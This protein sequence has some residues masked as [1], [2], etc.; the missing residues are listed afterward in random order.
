MKLKQICE[1]I[2]KEDFYD[3]Y[4]LA[5]AAGEYRVRYTGS[6]EHQKLVQD[7]LKYIASII[8]EDHMEQLATILINRWADSNPVSTAKISN[9]TEQNKLDKFYGTVTTTPSGLEI[10]KHEENPPNTRPGN[11]HILDKYN[12]MQTIMGNG[13]VKMSKASIEHLSLS[14]QAKLI[15]DLMH[16]PRNTQY[17][18]VTNIPERGGG[19]W[20]ELTKLFS[21]LSRTNIND[22]NKLVLAIDRIYGAIHHGGSITDYFDEKAWI[23]KALDTRAAAEPREILSLTSHNIKDLLTSG[24]IGIPMRSRTYKGKNHSR[25]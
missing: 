16:A 10:T 2:K 19:R 17:N 24:S 23:G 6:P 14:Q 5:Y 12:V 11:L 21:D 4:A 25:T 15:N 7:N 1:D 13:S 3:F 22:T 20:T 9:N 18:S 8:F